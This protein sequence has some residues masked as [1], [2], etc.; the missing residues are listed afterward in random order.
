MTKTVKKFLLAMLLGV[1][2]LCFVPFADLDADAKTI[3]TGNVEDGDKNWIWDYTDGARYFGSYVRVRN[4]KTN[5]VL[6]KGWHNIDFC[7]YYVEKGGYIYDT[8]HGGYEIGIPEAGSYS[9]DLTPVK[10]AWKQ[11]NGKWKY[12]SSEGDF[13]ADCYERINGKIYYFDSK[14]FLYGSGWQGTDETGRFYVDANGACKTGWL[15]DNGKWYFLDYYDGKAALGGVDTSKVGTARKSFYFFGDD[16]SMISTPG[17]NNLYDFYWVYLNKNGSCKTGWIK[18]GK[19]WHY[20]D[21]YCSGGEMLRSYVDEEEPYYSSYAFIDGYYIDT[22]GVCKDGGYGWH[23]DKNG[24]WF[25][26]GKFYVRGQYAYIDGKDCQFDLDGYLVYD[27]D[28][29]TGVY[30]YYQLEN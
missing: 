18:S 12:V 19:K 3:R 6:P 20:L 28:Y 25:G 26:K 14:G 30:T 15:Q 29:V 2:V 1:F 7:W 24:W 9:E 16:Y 27:Y 21:P 23:K 17:W 8:Y 10:W 4:K 11:V 13:L 5:E 22:E